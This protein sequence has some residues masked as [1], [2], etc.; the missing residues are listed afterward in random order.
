MTEATARARANIALAKY[1]G[2]ADARRN[3]PAVPSLSITLDPLVTETTVALDE[4]LAAD[5]LELGG[6]PAG[7]GETARARRLLDAV[8]ARLPARAGRGRLPFARVRSR[9]AFPTASGLASSASGFAALAGAACAAYGLR[10]SDEA[11]SALARAS[12]ASAARSVFGGFVTL[13]A[14][15]PGAPDD[16]PRGGALS[17]TPLLPVGHWDVAIVVAVADEGPKDTGSTDGMERSRATS[18]YYEAWVRAAP[19]LYAEVE[20]GVRARDLER[21]GVAMEQSTLAMHACAMASRPGI[22]YLRPPTLAALETVRALRRD[23]VGAYATMDAGPHVK[24]LCIASDITR[25]QAALGATPGVLRTI[26]ARP[27]PGLEVVAAGA[28]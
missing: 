24:V 2:K 15:D 11:L 16:D 28:R 21:T 5:T 6:A 27:G 19:G 18:P 7:P 8:R 1:W 23:G 3:L 22:V 13:A 26:V 17:A 12:S 14:G 25:V 20:A 9:N 10:A 4:T